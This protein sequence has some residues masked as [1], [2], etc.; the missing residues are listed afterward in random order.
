MKAKKTRKRL[1]PIA[2]LALALVGPLAAQT[3]QPPTFGQ[4]AAILENRC[5][6]CHIWALTAEGIRQNVVAGEPDSSPIIVM[7][8]NGLMP[9]SGDGFTEEEKNLVYDWIK[10]GADTSSQTSGRTAAPGA[11]PPPPGP[12]RPPLQYHMVSGFVASGSLLAAGAIGTWRLVD[13]IQKGHAYRNSIGF[14]E[15]GA[16]AAQL[17]LQTDKIAALWADPQGQPLRWTHVALLATGSGFYLYNTATG[18]GMLTPKDP[19]LTKR[20]LHR[21]AFFIHLGMM[22]GEAILGLVTSD[23]LR[24]GDHRLVSALTPVHAVLGVATPLTILASGLIFS[25]KI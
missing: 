11:L 9:P 10:A 12:S 25:M 18:L 7:V 1:V 3:T 19:T 4:V 21:T 2:A 5:S 15:N 20:D 14:P 17:S 16:T 23:A 22:S 13:L 8:E 6:A 24:R